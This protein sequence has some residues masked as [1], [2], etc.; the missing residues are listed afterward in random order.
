MP[1]SHELLNNASKLTVVQSVD[2]DFAIAKDFILKAVKKMAKQTKNVVSEKTVDIYIHGSYANNTN[3]FFPSNL[4]ICVELKVKPYAY[5]LT[6]NYYVQHELEFTPKAFR[7]MLF[8]TLFEIIAP[9][10]D[11]NDKCIIMEK[12]GKLRHTVEI[13]PC[14]SFEYTEV[15][16]ALF[17]GV[18]L[19]DTTKHADI[20]TFPKL[21]AKNGQT[22]DI[23]CEG[24]FRRI[25]RLFKSL[26]AVHSRE[27]GAPMVRGY[28]IECL[29][30]N[31]PDTLFRGSASGPSPQ[32]EKDILQ[33]IF[34]KVLNYLMHANI[35]GFV[36]QNLVWQLFGTAAEFWN[37]A[38]A[39]RFISAMKLMYKQ[40][41]PTR[42]M[43][44]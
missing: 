28:F 41:P 17:K 8:E 25:V 29:L 26:A 30:F 6:D 16:G 40:F 20:A 37:P 12:F 39:H 10:C 32:L 31:V 36:C 9:N 15:N 43:L 13:T 1:Y 19:H 11:Q 18:I 22:K 38:D 27:T 42:A 44:A 35:D 2:S 33:E 23:M 3:I 7:E 34:L 24:N 4:E 21:H 14:I 5:R